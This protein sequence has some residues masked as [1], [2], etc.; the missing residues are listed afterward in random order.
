MDGL[1][2]EAIIGDVCLGAAGITGAEGCMLAAG[3]SFPID[4]TGFAEG[5][6]SS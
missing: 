6:E 1:A 4:C 5:G 2:I 3:S